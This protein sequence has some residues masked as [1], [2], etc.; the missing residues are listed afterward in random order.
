MMKKVLIKNHLTKKN[1]QKVKKKL[2]STGKK[3]KDSSLDP[4]DHI[5]PR[6]EWLDPKAPKGEETRKDRNKVDAVAEEWARPNHKLRK[7]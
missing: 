1:F 4:A 2:R 5:K 7:K 3:I 6:E